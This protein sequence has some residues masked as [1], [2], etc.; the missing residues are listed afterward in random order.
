M[1]NFWIEWIYIISPEWA[2]KDRTLPWTCLKSWYFCFSENYYLNIWDNNIKLWFENAIRNYSKNKNDYEPII[3]KFCDNS[4]ISKIWLNFSDITKVSENWNNIKITTIVW[5]NGSGKSQL[6][7][8]LKEAITLHTFSREIINTNN[9]I[10]EIVDDIDFIWK[11][12]IFSKNKIEN[13]I[14]DELALN[15]NSILSIV[16]SSNNQ[17]WIKTMF[18]ML[19]NI[20]DIYSV[21]WKWTLVLSSPDYIQ[22]ELYWKSM[23]RVIRTLIILWYFSGIRIS[24]DF[25]VEN[26]EIYIIYQ[27]LDNISNYLSFNIEENKNSL[28]NYLNLIEKILFSKKEWKKNTLSIFHKLYQNSVDTFAS[29]IDKFLL[30]ISKMNLVQWDYILEDYKNDSNSWLLSDMLSQKRLNNVENFILNIKKSSYYQ[31]KIQ[32]NYWTKLANFS[33]N[34]L[35]WKWLIYNLLQLQEDWDSKLNHNI[36]YF[37]IYSSDKLWMDF[38]WWED[39]LYS[40]DKYNINNIS[41]WEKALLCRILSNISHFIGKEKFYIICID[42]PDAFL[43]I[44]RQKKYLKFLIEW[45][46]NAY[47]NKR[48]HLIIATHSPF[49]VSDIPENN[50]LILE[51]GMDITNAHVDYENKNKDKKN[52]FANTTYGIVSDFMGMSPA[53]W[54]LWDFT[55]EILEIFVNKHKKLLSELRNLEYK[56]WEKD[57]NN[58]DSVKKAI[59]IKKIDIKSHYKKY[60]NIIEGIGDEFLKKNLLHLID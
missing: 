33:W 1:E 38:Y 6:I 8:K 17:K 46:Y 18:N 4:F 35:I 21:T 10:L 54:T 27:T 49:I 20:E 26:R 39:I 5:E 16:D 55:K 41:S 44:R 15:N 43:H 28:L 47:P 34:D 11:Y 29:L 2:D 25:K 52:S 59:E 56:L 9:F 13:I 30:E 7:N 14:Y 48:F 3:H 19:F 22:Q 58:K 60:K 37:D 32:H 57:E 51:R 50:L 45:L 42:E 12:I 24:N 31:E 53:E 36:S 23:K 40:W